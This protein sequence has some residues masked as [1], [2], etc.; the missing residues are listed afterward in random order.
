MAFSAAVCA[1]LVV[2]LAALAVGGCGGAQ[3]NGVEYRDKDVA[4]RLGPTPPGMHRLQSD[5]ARIAMQNDAAGSTLAIGARCKQ[6]SDDVPL[7]ALVQHLF[8][9]FEDRQIQNEREFV[10]DGRTALRSELDARLD[11][12]RRHFIVV[13][14]KKDACVYD[15]M[16]VDGGGDAPLLQRSRADF[17]HMVEGVVVLRP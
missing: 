1:L 15:F 9:Q 6:D 12:V 3:F 14:M 5:D 16:H 8:L 4:F 10:L 13:V 2:S 11:G 7:R 17:D